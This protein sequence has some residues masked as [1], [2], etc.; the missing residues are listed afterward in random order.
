MLALDTNTISYFFRG[1]PRVVSRLSALAPADVAVP[2][3]VVYELHFGLARLPT[4]AREARAQ[5]LDNFLRPVTVLA[6]DDAAARSAARLRAA[7]EAKGTPIGPHDLLIAATALAHS[8]TL[9][10]RNI[11]EFSRVE[12]LALQDWHAE[13]SG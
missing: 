6:F 1:D 12:G 5:A 2:A 11:S 4:P 10:T 9:V 7:L 8:V 3:V 13:G